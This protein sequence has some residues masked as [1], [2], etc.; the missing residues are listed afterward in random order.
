[1]A[2]TPIAP[3]LPGGSVDFNA[4]HNAAKKGADL[5]KALEKAARTHP[6]KVDAPAE[7]QSASAATPAK[8]D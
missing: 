8:E 7:K 2:D 5:N 6:E 3:P 4:L 1:M